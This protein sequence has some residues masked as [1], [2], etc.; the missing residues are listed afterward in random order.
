ME[1]LSE[2]YI[3]NLLENHELLLVDGVEDFEVYAPEELMYKSM[4]LLSRHNFF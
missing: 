3:Y 4:T 1:E 2:K